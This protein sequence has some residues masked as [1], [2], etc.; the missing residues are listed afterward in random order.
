[1]TGSN[2]A[3]WTAQ[4]I[5]DQHGR[6]AVITGANTGIG[7]E[8]AKAL[9]LRGAEVVLAVRDTN[10][11]KC[12]AEEITLVAPTARVHVQRLDLSSLA[13][14]RDTAGGL[15]DAY[16]RIDL[17]INN[18]GVMYTPH[19]TTSDGYKLQFGTNHLGHFAL[20]GLLLDLLPPAS[21]VV[22][23]SSAGHRMGGPIDLDDLDWRR[24]PYDRT[25]SYGHSKLANLLF[26]YELDRRLPA[27]GPLAVAAHPGGADTTGSRSAMSHSSALTRAAFA[28]I[29]PLLLQSPERG[30]LPVLRAATDPGVRGGEYYG[31]RGFQQSKGYPKVV[32]SCPQSY[33]TELQRRLWALSQEMTGIEFPSGTQP[34]RHSHE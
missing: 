31:P 23:V 28:A 24:R 7:F 30:A 16:A 5:P 32:R 9:A 10:K 2:P 11:G 22:T 27:G 17:L 20:T 18:V 26:T 33:D 4:D 3:H 34:G 29:R 15:R 1:M 21:R 14:V 8:T 19:R 6:T 13:S 25:A 12:A